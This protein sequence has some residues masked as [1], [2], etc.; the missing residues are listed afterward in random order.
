MESKQFESINRKRT[1]EE[2]I[3]F[4]NQISEVQD[5]TRDLLDK[6]EDS[7][8]EL[9]KIMLCFKDP[10]KLA[11]VNQYLASKSSDPAHLTIEARIG[12]LQIKEKKE[13]QYHYIFTIHLNAVNAPA[14]L[15]FIHP[16]LDV[17]EEREVYILKNVNCLIH[18]NKYI[19]LYSNQQSQI[20]SMGDDTM[21]IGSANFD[22][23]EPQNKEL[24][25]INEV[26]IK[27]P[28][29]SW[30]EC[31][32]SVLRNYNDI[33]STIS[34]HVDIK[35]L[36]LI[37]HVLVWLIPSLISPIEEVQCKLQSKYYRAFQFDHIKSRIKDT[38][39]SF[40]G[41]IKQIIK[42]RIKFDIINFI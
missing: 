4:D 2:M 24:S 12:D 17:I 23:N 29:S 22:E 33:L 20:I 42:V 25:I 19:M 37:Q 3:K 41:I 36:I 40:V 1:H 7:K 18:E 35:H 38:K 27:K 8:I 16:E 5:E 9:D 10:N 30:K 21:S 11:Q 15:Y 14:Y 31:R 39:I 28:F 26:S 13:D 32:K 34:K 6:V